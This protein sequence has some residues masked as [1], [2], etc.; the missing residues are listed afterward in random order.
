[1][2]W[3]RLSGIVGVRVGT[4]NKVGLWMEV[5]ISG[6]KTIT[7]KG[8][9]ALSWITSDGERHFAKRVT[10]GK[11]ARRPWLRPALARIAPMIRRSFEK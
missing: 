2:T 5:G 8:K 11:I 4:N 1:V 7:A 9:K 6:G 10:Q 3:Q